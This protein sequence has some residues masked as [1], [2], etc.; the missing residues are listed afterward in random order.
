MITM[1][2]AKGTKF[3]TIFDFNGNEFTLVNLDGI[4]LLPQCRAVEKIDVVN[5][6]NCF[7]VLPVRFE[8]NG[9]SVD[10]FLVD[11]NIITRVSKVWMRT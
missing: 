2:R 7:E 5:S 3:F 9:T 11:D 1:A 8:L 6:L 10:G 4:I